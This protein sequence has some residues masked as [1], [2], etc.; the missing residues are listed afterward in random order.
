MV[1]CK[2]SLS[3][4]K[5]EVIPLLKILLALE[6]SIATYLATLHNIHDTLIKSCRGFEI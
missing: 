1:Q 4:K 5:I 3:E 6:I 2:Y